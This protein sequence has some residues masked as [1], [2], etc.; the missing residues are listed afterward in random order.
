VDN[1][2]N[3]RSRELLKVI[4]ATKGKCD[5]L[6]EREKAKDKECEELKA[7]CEAV[8]IDFDRNPTVI[9]LRKK[10][11]VLQGDVKKHKAGLERMSFPSKLR[12]FNK[13][14]G[15]VYLDFF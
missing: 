14:K 7:K 15:F 6:N 13:M 4:E 2:V 12:F 3:R 10:V 5:V 11:A 9:V 8:I 1:A